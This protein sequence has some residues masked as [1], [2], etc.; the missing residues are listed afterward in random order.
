MATTA[1]W[2]DG[3][4]P[5][6]VRLETFS[7]GV[8]SLGSYVCENLTLTRPTVAIR[9]KDE[10]GGPNGSVGVP[11][12]VTGTATV[13]LATSSSKILRPGDT[14]SDTFDSDLGSESFIVENVDQPEGQT[15]YKKV[16]IRFV[17]KYN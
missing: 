12:F 7:R 8:V 2:N 11:D 9:R 10:L 17:K 6:G 5:Y 4:I 13:Q 14:F 1:A 15:D 3:S 16:N